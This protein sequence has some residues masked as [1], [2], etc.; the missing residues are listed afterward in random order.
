MKALVTGGA[1]FIGSN[2]FDALLARGD[3]VVAFDN[4]SSGRRENL[5]GALAGGAALDEGD[6][7]VADSVAAAVSRLE[8]DVVFHLAAQV[9][10]RLAVDEPALDARTNVIGT[11][12]VLEAARAA[13][14]V[15]VVFAS[16][17]GAI[18]GEGE[19]RPLPLGERAESRPETAYGVSKLCGEHYLA[20]F[21][22][23]HSQPGVALRL[24]NVYGPR[25]DPHG[26]AGVVAIFCGRLLAG[27]APTVFGDGLQTRDYIY[28]GDVVEAMLRA[29]LILR[30]RGVDLEGPFNIGTG[31]ETSVV[32]L[33][34]ALAAESGRSSAPVHEPARKGEVNRISIDPAAA[35]R[36]LGW[37]P[38]TGLTA[39]LAATYR[40]LAAS[41]SG[42]PADETSTSWP[43]TA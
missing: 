21:R 34:D 25:Q 8:P 37:S 39:G 29:A 2:L 16:T 17:G 7:A 31:E 13:G 30:E 6:V 22:R 43:N 36:D 20:L 33:I 19:G 15:P 10:V 40:A 38:R 32:E 42:P 4:L 14:R 5:A 23:L 24:G 41:E 35:G 18:Y 1:G 12:N 9:D 28:V 27:E 26:E 11:V 3:E